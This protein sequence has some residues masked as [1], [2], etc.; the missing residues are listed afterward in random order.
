MKKETGFVHYCLAHLLY[1]VEQ[2]FLYRQFNGVL[3]WRPLCAIPLVSGKLFTSLGIFLFLT[4]FSQLLFLVPWSPSFDPS[5]RSPG[6]LQASL[7]RLQF[8][9][10]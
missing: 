4:A 3:C 8:S 2:L 7:P 1:L 10:V 5:I 6:K 9:S